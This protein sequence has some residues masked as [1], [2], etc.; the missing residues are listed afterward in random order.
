MAGE[1]VHI[2]YFPGTLLDNDFYKKQN[3]PDG[4]SF[5]LVSTDINSLKKTGNTSRCPK[6]CVYGVLFFLSFLL[7]LSPFRSQ[8]RG[9]FSRVTSTLSTQ[10]DPTQVYVIY[11]EWVYVKQH[12]GKMANVKTVLPHY[13]L[14]AAAF[15]C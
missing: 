7:L 11:L 12:A 13:T 6:L 8:S 4:S 2:T 10:F 3:K 15:A 5:I 1:E 9:E 14:I